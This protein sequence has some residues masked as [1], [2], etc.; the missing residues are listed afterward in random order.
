MLKYSWI[1]LD[2]QKQIIFTIKVITAGTGMI[3]QAGTKTFTV[4]IKQK[5]Y[6]INY[7]L[8]LKLDA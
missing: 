4:D 7:Q 3:F 6:I 2:I 5:M 1:S 8:H